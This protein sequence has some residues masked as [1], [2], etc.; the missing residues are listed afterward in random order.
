MNTKFEVLKQLQLF[1]E[2]N[3]LDLNSLMNCL[4]A[5]Y[6]SYVKGDYILSQGESFTGVGIILSGN[7]EI[8]K[9]DY[10]GKR[11][12]ITN[13]SAPDYFGEVFVCAGITT[14]PVSVVSATDTEIVVIDYQRIILTCSSSCNHHALLIKNMLKLI[15][16]KTLLLN[17]K[18]NFLL[19][20]GLR[21]KISTYLLERFTQVNAQYF[22]IPFDRAALADFLNVDRSALSRELSRM[23]EEKLIDYHKNS[24]QIVNLE[25]L[26][27]NIS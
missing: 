9:E 22:D 8:I 23:K 17:K 20:K 5:K 7:V 2:I 6:L 11:T 15:A 24:F 27:E 25:L 14:S 1:E 21:E 16:N 12:I 19:I 26:K 10:F 4:N 18:I 3:P 13:L